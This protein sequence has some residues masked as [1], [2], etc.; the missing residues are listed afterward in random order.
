NTDI[1]EQAEI[2]SLGAP[3]EYGGVQGAVFNLVTRE[4]PNQYQGGAGYYYQGDGLTG[5]NT[6]PEQDNDLPFHRVK[7][8]DVSAQMGGPL[9]KDGV[10]FVARHRHIECSAH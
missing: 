8:D 6:T 7:Y 9:E 1:F 10:R 3:A 2:L 4:G 5:R